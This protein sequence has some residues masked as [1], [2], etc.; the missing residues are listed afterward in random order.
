MKNEKM[1]ERFD[2]ELSHLS[3]GFSALNIA[4]KKEVLK[5]ARGLLKIQKTHKEMSGDRTGY[6]TFPG[7][8]TK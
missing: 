7:Q 3:K 6:S 5:T 4:Y 1:K 8:Y 2:K